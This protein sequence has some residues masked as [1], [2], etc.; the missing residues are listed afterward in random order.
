M[1]FYTK[2]WSIKKINAFL[3][4]CSINLDSIICDL[5]NF[6][7]I[8]FKKIVKK[9]WEIDS[10]ENLDLFFGKNTDLEPIFAL[11]FTEIFQNT[12]RKITMDN[13]AKIKY[14]QFL[15]EKKA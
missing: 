5:N 8:T 9:P 3:N 2:P 4:H 12:L 13:S 10:E 14:T 7:K 11:I 6:D 1:P 15:R